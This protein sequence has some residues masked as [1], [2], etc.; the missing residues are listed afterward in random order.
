MIVVFKQ[1]KMNL[2]YISYIM[3]MIIGD[4]SF[5]QFVDI[6]NRCFKDKYKSLIVSKDDQLNKGRY[7]MDHFTE[8]LDRI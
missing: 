3:I 5:N 4:M 2:R 7:R 8:L 6:C 1:D